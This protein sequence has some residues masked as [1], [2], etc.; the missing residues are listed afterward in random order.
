LCGAER[1]LYRREAKDGPSAQRNHLSL[2]AVDAR[3]ERPLLE[4]Q[5]LAALDEE[6][7][8]DHAPAEVEKDARHDRE[9]HDGEEG[10]RE[11][12]GEHARVDAEAG[13]PRLDHAL[14]L[15]H[16]GAVGRLAR[17]VERHRADL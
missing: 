10:Q 15:L 6:V 3:V 17:R 14:R 4:P 2:G 13:E 9:R 7:A 8:G 5:L 16:G 11:R 12:R 1:H